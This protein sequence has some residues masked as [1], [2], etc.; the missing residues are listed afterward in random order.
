M[1]TNINPELN[2]MVKRGQLSP[3][4]IQEL[5]R[6]KGIVD[7]FAMTRFVSEEE[8][9]SLVEK[10]GVEPDIQTWGD[11]FQTE[12]AS[13][14]FDLA[15]DDFTRIVDTI[16]FDMISATMIFQG[17]SERFLRK[18]ES[19]GLIAYGSDTPWTDREEESAHLYILMQYYLEMGLEETLIAQED[20]DWF[21]QFVEYA[22]F[23][24]G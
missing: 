17:K 19:D 18:V 6:L 4:K 20:M 24:V 16:R 1:E 13:R 15:D 12:I 21:N 14:F 8:L 7:R 11:Y 2:D 3:H 9:V 5:Q 10:F 23:A 22:Q